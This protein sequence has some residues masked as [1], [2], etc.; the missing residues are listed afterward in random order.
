[1]V[2][3]S[4]KSRSSK[5][6]DSSR[7]YSQTRQ[8]LGIITHRGRIRLSEDTSHAISCGQ[9]VVYRDG[10]FQ[11]RRGKT[12]D[13]VQL[14]DPK[15]TF[16]AQGFY[17]QEGPIAVRIVSR[18]LK[19]KI[20]AALFQERIVQAILLRRRLFDWDIYQALCLVH[21]EGDG[22]PAVTIDRYNDYIIVHWYSESIYVFREAIY[23][24]L[25]K[26]L[27]PKGI[28]EQK[29]F[30]PVN[31][32]DNYNPSQLI[33]GETAPIDMIIREGDYKFIVDVTS[34]LS[35]GLFSDL[36][37]ARQSIS[38]WANN[39]RVLNL[40]SYTG[41]LSIAAAYGNAAMVTAV[42]VSTKAHIWS[43]R[44]FAANN[45][46]LDLTK[47]ISGDAFKMLSQFKKERKRFDMII[48]DPP[49]FGSGRKGSAF[50][51]PKDY[52]NLV[53]ESL[54]VLEHGGIFM[55]I[56]SVHKMTFT[57]FA[58]AIGRGAYLAQRQLR[59]VERP[60][61]PADF[62]HTVGFVESNHLKCLIAV[63]D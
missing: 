26:E 51:A 49:A 15:G 1:M 23:D 19:E 7:K 18:N 57:Q 25:K 29:R 50:S 43:E 14:V 55:A 42:D 38:H 3:D 44:N 22:I 39:R 61:S 46:D 53:Q 36:R 30:E 33:F 4:S 40:F 56:C 8:R 54:A 48:L 60:S 2:Y 63:V 5:S 45:F 9:D 31:R 37:L 27:S 24:T 20:D 32:T 12:G 62:V 13:I 28:Y 41:A 16:V 21:A 35:T 34:P 10:E 11:Y 59:V 47:H 58:M 52:A 6:K 17:E